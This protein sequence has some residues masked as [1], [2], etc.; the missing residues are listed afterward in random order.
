[1][2]QLIHITGYAV[3]SNTT[4]DAAHTHYGVCSIR[5]EVS[6]TS[7]EEQKQNLMQYESST[8]QSPLSSVV[9]LSL[10]FTHL[11]HM[12]SDLLIHGL[13]VYR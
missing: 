11:K 13:N 10:S 2:M 5:F 8:L 1:M 12:R 9:E 4:H 6:P 3:F 7:L